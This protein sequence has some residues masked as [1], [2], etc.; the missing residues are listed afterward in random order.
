[1][2]IQ[3]HQLLTS[4]AALAAAAA[5]HGQVVYT[6]EHADIGVAL[7]ELVGGGYEF[8]P[9]FH[10]HDGAV[11]DG[12]PAASHGE[13]EAGEVVITLGPAS[14]FVRPAGALW[15]PTG[16]G[17]GVTLWR[18]PE[19]EIAG[20]PFLGIAAEEITEEGLWGELT[21]AGVTVQVTGFTGPLGGAFSMWTEDAF[22]DPVF[23]VSSAESL[24]GT[25]SLNEL[26][27]HLHFSYGF[28][29]P[30]LYEVTFLFS[31][32]LVLDGPISASGTYAFNVIPE[33]STYA[34]LAGAL[35]LGAV[36]WLRRRRS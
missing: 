15:S 31:G 28:T 19:A 7:H 29:E 11:L 36:V 23:V 34:A 14:A 9:H 21:P 3:P 5:L 25:F 33:P 30:G 12:V 35:A 4:A 32:E 1:M 17:S 20:L 10:Y 8:E 16:V 18:L 26:T 22:G 24:S 2:S 6:A 27:D 13:L